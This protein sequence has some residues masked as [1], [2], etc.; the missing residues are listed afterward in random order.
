M[1]QGDGQGP[2]VHA[3]GI[4][5]LEL[6]GQL[7]FR[8]EDRDHIPPVKNAPS[9]HMNLGRGRVHLKATVDEVWDAFVQFQES[10]GGLGSPSAD[11]VHQLY[12]RYAGFDELV[13]QAGRFEMLYGNQRMISPLDWSNTGR[14]WDGVRVQFGRDEW[15]LDGFFTQPVLGQGATNADTD[16]AGLYGSWQGEPVQIDLYAL[17]RRDPVAAIE[18]MTIGGLVEGDLADNLTFDVELAVQSGDHGVLDAGGTALAAGIDWTFEGGATVGLGY[19]LASGDDNPGDGNDDTFLP[20]F[21]FDH[22]YQGHQDIVVWRNVQDIIIR[23]SLP[24]DEGWKLI[25]AIHLLSRAEGTDALYTGMG[26]RGAVAKGTDE[27]IGTEV[28]V[29]LKGKLT[30]QVAL[31]TGVSQFLAGDGIRNGEDQLW[32]FVQIVFNF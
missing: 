30:D 8:W 3:P 18:D 23:G 27:A 17:R 19:E 29:S 21:N 10:I 2:V 16:F 15:S 11:T 12:G 14:A 9:D 13:L 31:W 32:L 4:D 20:L 24:V 1:A 26:G 5:S 22:Y 25:G 7:R 28:D 6:G